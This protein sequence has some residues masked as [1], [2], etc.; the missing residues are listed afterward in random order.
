[1]R[2]NR[3]LQDKLYGKLAQPSLSLP[4]STCQSLNAF[5]TFDIGKVLVCAR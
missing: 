1:M 2:R 3:T 5:L 4:D